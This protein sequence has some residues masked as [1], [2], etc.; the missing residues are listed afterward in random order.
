L[1]V[2]VIINSSAGS[3][4]SGD[5][6]IRI[7]T[8][9]RERDIEAD[10][11]ETS[12]AEI[13]DL[14]KSAIDSGADVITAAGGDGT[15]S[16]TVNS[17]LEKEIPFGIIPYGTLNHFAKD[18]GIPLEIE[19]A[20]EVIASGKIVDTDVAEVNGN[21]F[22]NNSSVGF[23]PKMVKHRDKEM[24]Q[25][26]Y[27]KWYAMLRALLNIFSRFPVLTFK[28]K[29]NDTYDEIR[30]PFIFVGNNRY[31]MD[32]FNLGTRDKLNE[33]LLSLHYPKTSGKWS[34]IRFAFLALINKL[35]EEKDF[36]TTTCNNI[37]INSRRNILEV[38]ADGEVLHLNTPLEYK[39]HPGR[40]KLLMPA[41]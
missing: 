16:S 26:G 6:I 41:K 14:I 33:G 13:K 28:I 10:I 31:S 11:L 30:T 24:K 35:H 20:V 1:K 36:I 25:S 18:A 22:I 23:Y 12:G 2:A 39:I 17:I 9:F 5:D 19:D 40:L 29:T 37:K 27:G 15:I 7:K 8:A 38:S 4:S 3:A 32:L 34:M 21:Y